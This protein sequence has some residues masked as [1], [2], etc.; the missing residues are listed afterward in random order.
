MQSEIIFISGFI[1]FIGLM[2]AIDLGLFGKSGKAVSMKR[3]GIMSAVW[4]TLALCF[5]ALIF[6]FGH[7]LHHVD[8]FAALQQINDTNF[9]HLQLNPHHF[10]GRLTLYRKNLPPDLTTYA[11]VEYSLSVDNT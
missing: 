5:Y 7:L 3:A 1:V 6:K 9:H 11:L 10:A 2:L 8:S 4:I